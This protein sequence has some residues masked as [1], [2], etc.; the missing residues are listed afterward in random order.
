MMEPTPLS[1][2]A[3]YAGAIVERALHNKALLNRL[4]SSE[5]NRAEELLTFLL[6]ILNDFRLYNVVEVGQ[7]RTLWG[8]EIRKSEDL[9][10]FVLESTIE[11]KSRVD[12]Q[13][14]REQIIPE[15]AHAF[16]LSQEGRN[17]D[18]GLIAMDEAVYDRLPTEKEIHELL[19]ANEWFAF[20][21][22]CKLAELNFGRLLGEL[23]PK[24]TKS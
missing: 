15:L 6:F 10:D 3:G 19:L 9:T 2:A 21:C 16:T 7:L 20:L 23:A 22:L 17:V 5:T 1:Q 11:L 24:S 12:P 4:A 8:E 14:W 18:G 13:H